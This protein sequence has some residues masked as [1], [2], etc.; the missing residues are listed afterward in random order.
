MVLGQCSV[1]G[2]LDPQG[3]FNDSWIWNQSP[4]AIGFMDP[5]RLLAAGGC[6]KFSMPRVVG[7]WRI[8]DLQAFAVQVCAG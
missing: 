5:S 2:H 4:Q 6:A 1:P 8:W 7:L 3:T